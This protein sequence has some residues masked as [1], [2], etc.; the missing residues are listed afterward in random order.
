M[1]LFHRGRHA[2]SLQLLRAYLASGE[3]RAPPPGIVSMLPQGAAAPAE[4]ASSAEDLAL[5]QELVLRIERVQLE[6][7]FNKSS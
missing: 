7:L 4:A 2:Q 5:T 1:L 6:G 3:A